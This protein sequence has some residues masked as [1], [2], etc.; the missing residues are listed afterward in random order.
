MLLDEHVFAIPIDG[1]ESGL[2]L[3]AGMYLYPSLE[4]LGAAQGLGP[5]AVAQ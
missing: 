1:T 2:Q 3:L 4:L 5:M